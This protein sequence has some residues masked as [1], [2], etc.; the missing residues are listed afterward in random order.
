MLLNPIYVA[1]SF[2]A[3]Q[4]ANQSGNGTGLNEDWFPA[5]THCTTTPGCIGPNEAIYNALSD[6]LVRLADRNVSNL[7]QTNIFD[8]LGN[9]TN[10]V[11]LTTTTFITYLRNR[12]PTF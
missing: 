12:K 1:M 2:T 9:D 11:P 8:K 7:A 10:G 4:G 3:F 5:L 6:L